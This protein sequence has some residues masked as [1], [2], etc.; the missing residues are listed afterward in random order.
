MIGLQ[1]RVNNSEIIVNVQCIRILPEHDPEVGEECVY[2]TRVYNQ[3]VGTIV[4]EFGNATGLG[5]K[6]LEFFET[7]SKERIEHAKISDLL[8][9]AKTEE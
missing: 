6:M 2:T 4:H 8:T 3:D 7:L 1:M 5:I 9:I